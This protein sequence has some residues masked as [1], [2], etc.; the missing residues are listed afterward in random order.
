MPPWSR[1]AFA[2][3]RHWHEG[4]CPVKVCVEAFKSRKFGQVPVGSLWDDDS[5]IVAE[6]PGSFRDVFDDG[7]PESD[8]D[9]EVED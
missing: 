4:A 8:P 9:V 7:P 2:C 6:Q 1:P 5:K 3:G